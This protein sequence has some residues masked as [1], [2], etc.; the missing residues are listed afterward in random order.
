ML[1]SIKRVISEV[2]A[3]SARAYS[4]RLIPRT[5]IQRKLIP[6]T[7]FYSSSTQYFELLNKSMLFIQ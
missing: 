3:Y 1:E 6:R 5:L 7:F 2:Y 4:A